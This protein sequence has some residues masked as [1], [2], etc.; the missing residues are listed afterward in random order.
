MVIPDSYRSVL[1]FILNKDSFYTTPK[2]YGMKRPDY[3]RENHYALEVA[4][5]RSTPE[6]F[7]CNVNVNTFAKEFR[8]EASLSLVNIR[9]ARWMT[10]L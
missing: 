6:L 5:W 10:C 7:R 3:R 4:L 8:S 2:V 9:K 1:I